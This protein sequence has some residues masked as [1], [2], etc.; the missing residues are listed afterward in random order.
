[1]KVYIVIAYDQTMYRLVKAF[2]N[3]DDAI[4]C[5]ADLKELLWRATID[6]VELDS[7]KPAK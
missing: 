6:C 5:R 2:T 4:R 3:E 7:Y 1:M